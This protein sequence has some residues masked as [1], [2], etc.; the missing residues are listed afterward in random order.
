MTSVLVPRRGSR[1]L[2]ASVLLASLI[3]LPA[4]PAPLASAAG[5]TY[6]VSRDACGGGTAAVWT[7][8]DLWIMNGTT[9]VG[10]GCSLTIEPGATVRAD[11]GVHLYVEG[12]LWSNGTQGQPILFGDNG[13]VVTPWAGIQFNASSEGS[14]S[15]SSFDRVQIAINVTGSSPPLSNNTIVQ[16]SAGVYLNDSASW[17]ADNVIDGRK[18]GSFG[19]IAIASNATMV[20]NQIN[21]TS[22]AIRSFA[23]GNLT[24]TDNVITNTSGSVATIGI[25]LDNLTSAV[26]TGNTV[27]TVIGRDA[28]P[29][30]VG[31]TAVGI[32]I[33]DAAS[34]VLSDNT[35]REDLGGRGGDGAAST[36]GPGNAGGAGGAAAGIALGSA[37]SV[38]AQG[39]TVRDLAGNRGGDGGTST[40]G[41]GGAGGPGGIAFALELFSAAGNVSFLGNTV[42]NVTGGEG[43]AG[44]AGSATS[45]GAGGI[46]ADA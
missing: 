29:G 43:G 45:N 7:T 12:K 20:G 3:L 37:G 1:L 26:L 17:V 11:P 22:F 19:I 18:L 2:I 5:N 10:P 44:V 15:W 8:G 4:L 23:G 13:T 31:G 46:G 33:N 6:Y 41:R 28:G 9:V 35:V 30:G 40:I 24:L 42:R 38:L 32:L 34:V 14:V 39:N 21:G 16:A 25:Y 27:E 36:I